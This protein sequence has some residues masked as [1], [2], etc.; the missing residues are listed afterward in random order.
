MAPFGAITVQLLDP[1]QVD[2][3]H[4]ADLQ[5]AIAGQ[6]DGFGL[7]C[8]MQ[9]FVEQHIGIGLQRHPVGEGSRRRAVDL[10]LVV[11]MDVMPGLAG[12]MLGE[13]GEDS[14]QLI[15]QIGL[16]AEMAEVVV[17]LFGGL[18]DLLDHAG[19]VVG[20]E[21][22]AFDVGGFDTFAAEDLSEGVLH[23][24]GAGSGRSGDHDDR[25]LHRHGFLL[26]SVLNGLVISCSGCGTGRDRRTVANWI[27]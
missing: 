19:P 25:V 27:G 2:D 15:E 7:R 8:A 5:I 16:G 1:L 23:R 12:A 6:I 9:S 10:C 11:V 21:G 20:V 18:G 22:I 13:L 26:G 17:A 3:R 4:H 14:T 24:R